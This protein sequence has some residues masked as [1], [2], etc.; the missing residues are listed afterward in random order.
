MNNTDK[1]FFSPSEQKLLKTLGKKKMSILEL[2][3]TMF[4]DEKKKP[5]NGSILVGGM[6]TRIN[7]KCAYHD[8][9]WYLNGEGA[10][11][12]GKTVWHELRQRLNK[13][14]VTNAEPAPPVIF[15]RMYRALVTICFNPAAVK[16]TEAPA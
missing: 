11:R 7:R 1:S 15:G 10:G 4:K 8:L 2:T 3:D 13:T 16:A 5:I 6:V 12:A 14:V 9:P